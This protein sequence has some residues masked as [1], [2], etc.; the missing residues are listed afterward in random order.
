M[1]IT[2][3]TAQILTAA[4]D[5]PAKE[6][7]EAEIG[8]LL[9]LPPGAC[10]S[11]ILIGG[12]LARVNFLLDDSEK[13]LAPGNNILIGL[14]VVDQLLRDACLKDLGNKVEKL[15]DLWRR[16]AGRSQEVVGDGQEGGE[17]RI[18]HRIHNVVLIFPSVPSHD[19]EQRSETGR[20]SVAVPATA[21][22]QEL[23]D[24]IDE[25]GPLGRE[26]TADHGPESG[27]N[28]DANLLVRRSQQRGQQALTNGVVILG[29][30]EI[31]AGTDDE[32]GVPSAANA[33]LDVAAQWLSSAHRIRD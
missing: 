31:L 16:A 30:D 28:M 27:R 24:L 3:S 11:R 32:V 26:V 19:F 12:Q 25:R 23:L 2:L 10:L 29:G 1:S 13:K 5:S 8:P 18:G 9:C 22:A 7:V 6:L 15:A 21:I 20:Y 4:H 33:I 14:V 17:G